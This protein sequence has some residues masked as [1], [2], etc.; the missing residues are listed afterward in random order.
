MVNAPQNACRTRRMRNL[1]PTQT[2]TDYAY[3]ACTCERE[4]D[5]QAESYQ[6]AIKPINRH[7]CALYETQLAK[8]CSK[9]DCTRIY[10][11]IYTYRTYI[12]LCNRLNY[13]GKWISACS[14][15]LQHYY[16]LFCGFTG[17]GWHAGRPLCDDFQ[18]FRRD[19]WQMDVWLTYVRYL[20]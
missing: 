19:I 5:R 16:Q 4:R 10:T 14:S 9:L 6:E 15:I 20:E 1:S 13:L 2:R 8:F 11:Y 17:R 3:A 7:K 18:C 12:P